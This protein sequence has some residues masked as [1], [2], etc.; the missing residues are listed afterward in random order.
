[1]YNLSVRGDLQSPI[2]SFMDFKSAK[3]R[4]LV[5]LHCPDG[6]V[7]M[8]MSVEHLYTN[9]VCGLQIRISMTTDYKSAGTDGNNSGYNFLSNNDK[10]SHL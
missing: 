4:S 10:K 8:F 2:A 9:I 7:Y 1:M 3:T 6:V 5:W